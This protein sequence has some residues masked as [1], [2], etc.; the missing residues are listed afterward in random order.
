MFFAQANL[1]F[2]EYPSNSEM[3]YWLQPLS[4]KRKEHLRHFQNPENDFWQGW[5]RYLTFAIYTSSR[6]IIYV[7]YFKVAGQEVRWTNY[8]RYLELWML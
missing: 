8:T 4:Y 3:I 2:S 7:R 6:N 1:E 5:N